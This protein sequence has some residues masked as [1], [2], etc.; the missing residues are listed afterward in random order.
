MDEIDLELKEFQCPRCNK[1][2][3][4]TNDLFQHMRLSYSDP[5]KCTICNKQLNCMANILSHSYRNFPIT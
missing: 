1:T 2:Y 3:N 5:T 4:N